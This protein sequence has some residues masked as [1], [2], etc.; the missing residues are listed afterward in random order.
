MLAVPFRLSFLDALLQHGGIFGCIQ[1]GDRA[2]Q[3]LFRRTAHHLQEKSVCE[4]DSVAIVIDDYALVQSL[5]N[6]FHFVDP[7]MLRVV[8]SR[9][10]AAQVLTNLAA[11][12]DANIPRLAPSLFG[13]THKMG[14]APG[15]HLLCAV[16]QEGAD[17]AE[18]GQLFCVAEPATGVSLGR[19]SGVWEQAMGDTSKTCI[20]E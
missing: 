6:A 1:F 5:Q 15:Q 17:G 19:G 2:P 8:Q 20:A 9:L 18:S 12:F 14:S 7:L 13:V 3:K 4:D 10:R 11:L 16:N